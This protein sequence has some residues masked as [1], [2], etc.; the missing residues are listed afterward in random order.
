VFGA[1]YCIELGNFT[2]RNP[3]VPLLIPGIGAQGNEL[4]P[5]L[6]NLHTS[7]FLI[8]SSR[9]I[10]YPS[11][12]DCTMQDFVKSVTDAATSLNREINRLYQL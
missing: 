2:S 7:R 8:N 4:Q 12:S 3:D 9:A 5:L 1:N 6:D 11:G 10:I